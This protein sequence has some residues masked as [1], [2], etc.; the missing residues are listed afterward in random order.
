MKYSNQVR[1]SCYG[2][3][4][5]LMSDPK[6]NKKTDN[7]PALRAPVLYTNCD[8]IITAAN[9]SGHKTSW[10]PQEIEETEETK[11][12]FGLISLY[13]PVLHADKTEKNGKINLMGPRRGLSRPL[14]AK[15]FDNGNTDSKVRLRRGQP[16]WRKT[17]FNVIVV[18]AVTLFVTTLWVSIFQID[19]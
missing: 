3:Y 9:L 16:K 8:D 1:N 19:G 10:K 11:R 18:S 17:I 5:E 2:K 12:S 4:S 7:L 13:S 15:L 6:E 14:K